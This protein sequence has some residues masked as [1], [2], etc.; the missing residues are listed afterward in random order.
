[1]G[2]MR[3]SARRILSFPCP[4]VVFCSFVILYLFAPKGGDHQTLK[5]VVLDNATLMDVIHTIEDQ[6]YLPVFLSS[7]FEDDSIN[8]IENDPEL[9]VNLN[10]RKIKLIHLLIE[11]SN[12]ID[13]KAKPSYLPL[14]GYS[15]SRHYSVMSIIFRRTKP[16]Q[17]KNFISLYSTGW[18]ERKK[19]TW[20]GATN[21]VPPT[22]D[23]TSTSLFVEGNMDGLFDIQLTSD[24]QVNIR[25]DSSW[26]ELH[27][28]NGKKHVQIDGVKQE[29]EGE[30]GIYHIKESREKRSGSDLK[31]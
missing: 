13:V 31:K 4:I 8:N 17:N 21:I 10:R 18:G 24:S 23:G 20:L 29:V 19:R 11:I 30:H 2:T 1:M 27:S 5:D 7:D 14:L 15:M 12:Q 6:T 16:R 26:Y 25:L 9:R 28:K 22:S 3:R